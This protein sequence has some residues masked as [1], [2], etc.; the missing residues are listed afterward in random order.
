MCQNTAIIGFLIIYEH[1]LNR[2]PRK[3]SSYFNTLP[4]MYKLEWS[5]LFAQDTSSEIHQY[6]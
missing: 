4:I 2:Y 5:R 6:H 1:T 3:W